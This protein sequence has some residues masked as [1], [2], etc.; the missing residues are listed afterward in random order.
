MLIFER[1]RPISMY[2]LAT[3]CTL[4]ISGSL[5]DFIGSRN[6]FLLG[7]FTQGI[8]SM[9]SGLSTTG[10]TLI[11]F[12]IFSGLATSLCLPSAVSLISENFYP[13]RLQNLAFAC[14]GG[15]QPIG[16]GLGLTLGGVFTDTVGWPWSFHFVAIVNAI[17]LVFAAWQLPVKSANAPPVTWN[18]L[19]FKIDWI[20]AVII[21]TSLGL[22][23]YI[24]ACVELPSSLNR[25]YL[26]TIR[27]RAVTDE[28]SAI[29]SP[30][31]IIFLSLSIILMLVFFFW[32]GRQERKGHPALI[33]NSL[34]SNTA[35][36]SICMN[37][38]LTWGAFN[39]FEQLLNFFFQEVQGLKAM[40]SAW[41]FI[42]M[43]VSGLITSIVTGLILHRCRA[44]WIMNITTAIS[45]FSPFLMVLVDPS[46]SYWSCVFPAIFLN[47]V[48]A[49]S[50]FTVS[51]I[52]IGS[53]FPAEM[54]GLAGGVFNTVSQ[55]GKS[56][57]LALVALISN[58]VTEGSLIPD[59]RSP[60]A[61]MEGYRAS[62]LFLFG[63]NVVS[64]VV[65]G[66]GLRKV[67]KIGGERKLGN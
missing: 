64:L 11:I 18:G 58:R 40:E 23:S 44:D 49:D 7:C 42:P 35:F 15:G 1:G 32:V 43:P 22:I 51:N 38:M 66:W 29:V 36:T 6:I 21:S 27:D 8:F 12:R 50:L 55:I 52:L 56:M 10:T 25:L 17:V 61:L 20:G 46:W 9:A 33:S 47:A 28:S 30:S 60:E 31:N 19:A 24:L 37:V 3:G 65:G 57:G 54:Q 4:L 63:V 2:H 67:G 48:G 45:C 13:G 62:F 53:V 14:M 41:R 39:A 59:K 26:L 5:S 34:W 16:Y